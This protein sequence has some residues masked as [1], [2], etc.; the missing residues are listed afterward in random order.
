MPEPPSTRRWIRIDHWLEYLIEASGL[1]VFMV[2][3][4]VAAVALEHPAS[5]V[6]ALVPAPLVRRLLM[7]LTMG[8]T[9]AAIIYSR[10]GERSGAHLNPAVTLA[11]ARLGR[12]DPADVFGYVIAHF[13]GAMVGMGLAAWLLL[14]ALGHPGVGWVVTRPGPAGLAAAGLAEFV[15]TFVLMST[16][17]LCAASPRA[18]RFTGLAAAAL[19][20]IF[21]TVEAPISGMS[22][23]PARS[24][25]PA[26][27]SGQFD[28]LWI[29]V[30]APPLGTLTA[31]EAV[32]RV[33]AAASVACAKLQH[34]RGRC[35]FR[36]RFA[37]V[38]R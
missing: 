3:A 34:G 7:G 23:N 13:V 20:A 22:L 32:C 4:A 36:C 2:V 10:W 27:L 28:A 9:A 38:H 21:I 19:V 18:Q 25:A 33:R 35:I 5:A 8:T 14:P 26:V 15:M 31:A 16:V 17:L 12:I 29:Y 30:V 24:L 6:H 11:F 1:G 37:E